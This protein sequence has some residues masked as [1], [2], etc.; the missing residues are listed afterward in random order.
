LGHVGGTLLDVDNTTAGNPN[1]KVCH[2]ALL[3]QPTVNIF[4]D[5]QFGSF[6]YQD[7]AA[8]MA[9]PNC[10]PSI[11]TCYV[12]PSVVANILVSA[13]TVTEPSRTRFRD[14]P[15]GTPAKLAIGVMAKTGIMSGYPDG[16]FRPDSS[17]TREQF[18]V[19][20]VKALNLPPATR[21]LSFSDLPARDPSAPDV[22][23]AAQAGLLV[24]PSPTTFGPNDTLTR[25]EMATL[26]ARGFRLTGGVTI[27]FTDGNQ[28]APW[29]LDNVRAIV[30][31]GYMS[32]YAD[33][34]FKPGAFNSR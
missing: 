27:D 7:P 8:E 4:L 10:T 11:L 9:P 31:A 3:K 25:Q 6:M 33:G 24:T 16:T 5:R 23:S 20:L 29:A 12:N 21:P 34:T 2:G 19:M 17:L 14:V 13:L 26:M 32:G 18:V 30:G 22:A 1:C 15:N 28:I